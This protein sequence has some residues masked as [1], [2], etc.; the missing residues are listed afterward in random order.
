MASSQGFLNLG[1]GGRMPYGMP[2]SLMQGLHTNSS[3]SSESLNVQ[4]PQLFNLGVS[5]PFGT[6]QQSFTPFGTPQQSLTNASLNALRQQ[7]EETNLEMVNLVTQQVGMVINP[8]IRD[9]NNSYQALS[10]Q[11]ERIGN[12]LGAPPARSIPVPQN[13][14]VRKMENSVEEQVNQVVIPSFR[15]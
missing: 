11:M 8:L 12:F 14:N 3:V 10:L 13:V 6:P 2:T 5:V 4:M 15:T 7:I 9:T 1:T